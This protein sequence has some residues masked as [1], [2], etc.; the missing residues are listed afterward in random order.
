MTRHD[1]ARC[2]RC[3]GT[4]PIVRGPVVFD[5]GTCTCLPDGPW[6]IYVCKRHEHAADGAPSISAPYAGHGRCCLAGPWVPVR[7]ARA[8]KEEKE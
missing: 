3:G 2:E 6:T 5:E 7:V 4:D 1:G 8:G